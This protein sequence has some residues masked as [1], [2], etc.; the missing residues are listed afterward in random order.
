MRLPEQLPESVVR[1]IGYFALRTLKNANLSMLVFQRNVQLYP[2]SPRAHAS[3][4]DA[5]LARADTAAAIAQL[6]KAVAVSRATGADLPAEVR[7]MLTTLERGNR[8]R[9]PDSN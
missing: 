2:Q 4:A 3:L 6:R 8:P 7:A 5:Y 9:S 1:R